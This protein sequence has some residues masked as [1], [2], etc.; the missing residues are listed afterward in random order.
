MGLEEKGA[1]ACPMVAVLSLV[2]AC[3]V[4]AVAWSAE[5]PIPE[6]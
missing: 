3:L 5:R 1:L 4:V 2:E 6:N